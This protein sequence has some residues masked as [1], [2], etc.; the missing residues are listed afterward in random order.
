MINTD[1][2]RIIPIPEANIDLAGIEASVLL[3]NENYLLKRTIF[4]G[5]TFGI[6]TIIY[7]NIRNE[8]RE[9]KD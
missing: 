1:L 2:H 3:R 5:I 8:R 6:I 4:I 7:L 9:K